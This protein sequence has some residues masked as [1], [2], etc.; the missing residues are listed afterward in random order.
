MKSALMS[1]AVVTVVVALAGCTTTPERI[2]ELEQARSTVQ[3]LERQ[4]MAQSTSAT[5]MTKA[6]EALS[7]ADIAHENGA[8]LEEIRHEAYL[9]RLY[10]EIGLELIAEAEALEQIK[11]A[12]AERNDVQLQARTV[13]AERAQMIAKQ[14]TAQAKQSMLEAEAS[15]DVAD[16]A[17][18]EAT[19]LADELAELEAEET[20]RG[21]VLTLS[22]DVLFE[23]D[24][25]DLKDGAQRAMGRLADFLN[26][27]PEHRLLIE[28]HTDSRGADEYNERLA[29]SRADAVAE[30]LVQRGIASDRLRPVGLGESY[31][32]ASNDTTAG[33]QQN[34]RVEIVVSAKDGSF[35]EGADRSTS[36]RR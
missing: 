5:Q 16:A 1:L 4:P 10:A 18:Q 15:R 14:Q 8:P 29:D 22:D 34:R 7:R 33:R 11:A 25:A 30:T 20:A 21:L 3:N 2:D 31:P 35:P 6:R 32:V 13:E 26:D 12:E 28:G 17:I 19:R 24:S 9:A 36:A 27:Y 23:T